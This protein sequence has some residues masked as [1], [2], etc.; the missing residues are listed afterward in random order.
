MSDD[1]GPEFWQPK[2]WSRFWRR[3]F[4]VTLPISGPLWVVAVAV[5]HML[6]VLFILFLALPAYGLWNLKEELWDDAAHRDTED[7]GS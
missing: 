6:F 3:A 5:G 4:L 1:H 7:A 2:A